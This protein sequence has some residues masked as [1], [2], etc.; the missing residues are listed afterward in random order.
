VI[1]N[2]C[3]NCADKLPS[4]VTAVQS[5]DHMV[6]FVL[7]MVNI[8]SDDMNRQASLLLDYKKN[9]KAYASL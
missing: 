7:P 4:S 2:V 5:S 8:G 6:A 9:K 1:S 3:S